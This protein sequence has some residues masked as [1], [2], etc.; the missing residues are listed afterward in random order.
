MKDIV[1]VVL[2]AGR[3]TR[4]KSDTPKV[5]HELLGRPMISYVLE[6]LRKS[7]ISDIV[8]VAG[9][10]A[11]LL[12]ECESV[13]GAE[14]IVQRKL[15]GSGDAVATAKNFVEKRS[16]DILVICGDTPLIKTETIRD[17]LEKHKDSGSSLTLLTA[18]VKDPTGYGRIVRDGSGKI[19]KI[20]EEEH[21]RLY[22]EIINEVNV[23]VY[24][25]KS[26]DLFESLKKVEPDPIKKEIFL[27]DTVA[28]LHKAGRLISSLS[29]KD[30]SE[31]IGINSRADLAKAIGILK[32]RVIEEVMAIGA[33]VEDPATTTIYPGAK[34][35]K[36]TIIHPNTFIGPD[37]A[38]GRCCR[39][40]PFAR[41]TANVS[42]GDEVI[43]GNFVELVRPVIDDRTKIK[44]HTYLGDTTVGKNVNIGA[45]TITAN[46]DGK[47]K[48]KTIIEDD[49]F[50]GVG[51]RLVAPV[52]IGQGAIVGAGC[53]VLRGRDVPSGS[54]VVGV[55]A[56]VLDKKRG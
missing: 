41:L 2:A 24:C 42:I 9:Y 14:V 5:L 47:N 48:N 4:M 37:V 54:T 28:I 49:S 43:I 46:Y 17:L 32:N 33:T 44:H 56:R 39:I 36:D 6:S 20:V 29:V 52:R 45:G 25:F 34:I 35:G 16:S 31:M 12:K 50:I 18:E 1:A 15:L 51:A 26:E 3:G 23:G 11:D 7:G 40:G 55:P 19:I 21:A 10:G 22:E 27:T 30:S 8:I 13:K 38:I 53:V